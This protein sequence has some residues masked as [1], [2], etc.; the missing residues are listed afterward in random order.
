MR[1]RRLT[2]L[3]LPR[4]LDGDRRR[5]VV[6]DHPAQDATV[7]ELAAAAI[8]GD[9]AAVGRLYD[10]L[11]GPIYRYVAMRVRHRE[12]AED[13]T[14][15]VFERIVSSLPRYRERGRPFSAFAFRVAHNA[16]I[17][18]VRRD[19][20]YPPLDP[21]VEL[22]DAAV[23]VEALSVRGEEL[24]ELQSAL[25]QLTPDQQEAI[26]LRYGAGLSAEEA[27]ATMGRSA[28]TVRALTFRAIGALRRHMAEPLP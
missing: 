17:D 19:R 6:A 21:E 9:V 5:V 26:A 11:V 15:A 20:A 1:E 28:N 12:D 14:Q 13:I 3:P 24:R 8:G 23:G 22:P 16:V 10:A 18:H 2:P 4:F 27:G 7:D 25:R